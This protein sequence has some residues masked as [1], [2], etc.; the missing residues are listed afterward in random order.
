MENLQKLLATSKPREQELRERIAYFQRV[1]LDL[2]RKMEDY[3]RRQND[4]IKQITTL[5]QTL[6]KVTAERN[7][8]KVI[9]EETANKLEQKTEEC[10]ALGEEN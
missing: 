2:S 5:K 8:F 10:V 3:N 9:S 7:L 4:Y 6:T 1:N